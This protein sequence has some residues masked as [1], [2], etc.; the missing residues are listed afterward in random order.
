MGD[1][2]NKEDEVEIETYTVKFNDNSEEYECKLTKNHLI[3]EAEF[4]IKIPFL[5]ILNCDAHNPSSLDSTYSSQPQKLPWGTATLKYLDE[6]D[7]V[8]TLSLQ[9]P[10][11]KLTVFQESIWEQTY[12]EGNLVYKDDKT[13]LDRRN[14]F[15][16]FNSAL[17]SVDESI[18]EEGGW[19]IILF[20]SF[21]I[22]FGIIILPIGTIYAS[23]VS[24]GNWIKGEFNIG[25]FFALLLSWFV[26]LVVYLIL[27]IIIGSIL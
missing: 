22:L 21:I 6:L 4:S 10:A 7:K 13:E 2:E 27:F 23:V 1:I 3:I 19:F 26:F 15:K 24:I 18:K 17:K 5:R 11:G 8:K 12:R 9:I 20:G 25:N 14:P 16:V